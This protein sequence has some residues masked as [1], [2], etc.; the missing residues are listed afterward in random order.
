LRAE[1]ENR[2]QEFEK[3]ERH[4]RRREERREAQRQEAAARIAL[5]EQEAARIKAEEERQRDR[6]RR[7][8]ERK[9]LREAEKARAAEEVRI[10]K[11][12]EDKE[13][14]RRRQERMKREAESTKVR[15]GEV[16]DA[17]SKSSR[18]S[19]RRA[20]EED[21]NPDLTTPVSLKAAGRRNSERSSQAT[22]P[23][24]RRNSLFGSM[25]GSWGKDKD[26]VITQT[27]SSPPRSE[28]HSP[29]TEQAIVRHSS[30][31]DQ[32][33]EP[34]EKPRHRRHDSGVH[35][36]RRSRTVS[37]EEAHR[38]RKEQRRIARGVT[39]P[40]QSP[41]STDAPVPES[42]DGQTVNLEILQAATAGDSQV[43][44]SITSTTQAAAG[45]DETPRPRSRRVETEPTS[46]S[47]RRPE[48]RGSAAGLGLNRRN[49]ERVRWTKEDDR[50]PGSKNL[51]GFKFWGS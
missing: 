37:E 20:A 19:A 6:E 49:S 4:R 24:Q 16:S 17:K 41:I 44:P 14:R 28:R 8:Q 2:Q 22:S 21:S 35:H 48:P 42:S 11:E 15:A 33:K 25:F 38:L 30:P 23:R 32:S 5:Q 27:R 46:R 50:R 10:A 45:G 43:L 39:S 18:D 31:I 36:R 3:A 29:E 13:R 1:E 34:S 7:H 12:N 9:A 51:F 26:K 47:S 40:P